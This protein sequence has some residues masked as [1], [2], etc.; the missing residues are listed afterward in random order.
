M[1]SKMNITFSEV[2]QMARRERVAFQ[3]LFIEEKQ[4][5]KEMLNKHKNSPR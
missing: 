4:A 5:E 2:K 1:M 3:K